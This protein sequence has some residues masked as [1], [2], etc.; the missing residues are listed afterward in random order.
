MHTVHT[1]RFEGVGVEFADIY[2]LPA[3]WHHPSMGLLREVKSYLDYGLAPASMP[4]LHDPRLIVPVGTGSSDIEE[5]GR[6]LLSCVTK[7]EHLPFKPGVGM[8][9]PQVSRS[10]MMPARRMF[11]AHVNLAGLTQAHLTQEPR[12]FIDPIVAPVESEGYNDHI[13][14]CFSAPGIAAIVRRYNVVLLNGTR[15]ENPS[16][17]VV[18]HENDHLDAVLCVDKPVDGVLYYVPPELYEV[19]VRYFNKGRLRGWPF[20]F[21][22]DQLIAMKAG[23]WSFHSYL[24]LVA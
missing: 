23:A 20:I 11:A 4:Q 10:L 19:F 13:E 17:R 9:S 15:I 21:S 1:M 16:S 6:F 7:G 22:Q 2:A 18:Q 12:L 5:E 3:G 8:A 14:R 24:H